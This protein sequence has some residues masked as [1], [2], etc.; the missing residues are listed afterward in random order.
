MNPE[1]LIGEA[2]RLFAPVTLF[3]VSVLWLVINQNLPTIRQNLKQLILGIAPGIQCLDASILES[4]ERNLPRGAASKIERDNA[5]QSNKH[6]CGLFGKHD[7]EKVHSIDNLSRF[8]CGSALVNL[9]PGLSRHPAE[10]RSL[11]LR[12]QN[13]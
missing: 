10:F 1:P 2:G 13:V 7:L 5:T 9:N 4:R 6:R 3:G 12:P 8:D 11:R